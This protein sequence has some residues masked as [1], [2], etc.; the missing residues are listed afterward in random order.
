MKMK[1]NS[2][3]KKYG[4][5]RKKVEN[6]WVFLEFLEQFYSEYLPVVIIFQHKEG[7]I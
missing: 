7:L 3:V 1:F 2:L 6:F 5:L 4:V